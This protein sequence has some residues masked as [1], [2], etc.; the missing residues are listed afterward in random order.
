MIKWF[1]LAFSLLF[2]AA[3]AVAPVKES[4][5]NQIKPGGIHEECV[6]AKKG[7]KIVYSFYASLPVSFNLHYHVG[8]KIYYPF[9]RKAVTLDNGSYVA[10]H[11]DVYCLMWTNNNKDS[12]TVNYKYEIQPVVRYSTTPAVNR[13]E[14]QTPPARSGY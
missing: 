12:A 13:P 1:A 2:M 11:E 6:S 7:E 3:C 8:E 14:Q 10:D 9:D 4:G 5:L